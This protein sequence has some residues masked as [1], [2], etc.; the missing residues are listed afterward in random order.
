MADKE[1][2]KFSEFINENS[3]AQKEIGF[4]NLNGRLKLLLKY[5]ETDGYDTMKPVSEPDAELR[6]SFTE[7]DNG[8]IWY[9]NSS[10]YEEDRKMLLKDIRDAA[11]EFDQ[12]VKE[13][14]QKRN[15]TK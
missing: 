1:F 5:Q 10:D 7:H 3:G 13:I 12:K 2:P 6:L 4:D 14:L 8:Q 11:D 15:F 9:Y